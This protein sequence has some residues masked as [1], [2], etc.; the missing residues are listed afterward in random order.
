M[1]IEA[2]EMRDLRRFAGRWRVGPFV[3]GLNVLAAPNEAGKS[4]LLA[5]LQAAIFQ[6]HRSQADEVRALKRADGGP[7]EVSLVLADAA[8]T[9]TITKRFAGPSGRAE[10]IDVDGRRLAGD[11]AEDEVRRL[12]GVAALP[13]KREVPR[14]VWGALWVTQGASFAQ[15]TLD[16]PARATLNDA[17]AAQVGVVTGGA[18]ARRIRARIDETLKGLQTPTGRPSGALKR[19][20]DAASA[21]EERL[22]LLRTRR[23]GVETLLDRVA[24]LRDAI[25]RRTA[26]STAVRLEADLATAEDALRRLEQAA[27]ARAAAERAAEDAERLAD[28]AAAAVQRRQALAETAQA[29]A[30]AAAEAEAAARQATARRDAAIRAADDARARLAAARQAREAAVAALDRAR[31]IAAL[32]PQAATAAEIGRQAADAAE[33]LRAMTDAA[34]KRDAIAVTPPIMKRLEALSERLVAVRAAAESMAPRLS[35]TVS[36]GATVRLDGVTLAPGETARAVLTPLTIEVPGQA[37]IRLTPADRAD[38]DPVAAAEAELAAALAQAGVP[39]LA[40]ARAAAARREA[41]DR[42]AREAEARVSALAGRPTAEAVADLVQR[43]AA[44]AAGLDE[45]LAALGL[46]AVPPADAAAQELAAAERAAETA[47]A[48]EAAAAAGAT[49]AEMAER[50]AREEAIAAETAYAAALREADA[51]KA[52][53]AA[54]REREPDAMLE[55][56]LADRLAIAAARRRDAE[57]V[58]KADETEVTLART[59]VERLRSALKTAREDAA[60]EREALAAAEAELRALEGDALDEAIAREEAAAARARREADQLEARRAALVLL[61]EAI[62]TAER[63]ATERYLAPVSQRLQ[64]WLEALL[65]GARAQLDDR[66]AVTGLTRD[67]RD[68]PFDILSAGTQEQIAVLVRLAFADL[69]RDQGRAAP[70]ILD[71]ALVFSD[72]HRIERMFDILSAASVRMQIVVLTCRTGLFARLG[73]HRLTLERVA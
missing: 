50:A 2:I 36:Q 20:L 31:A 58:P 3:P 22:A 51:A 17:L 32:P 72:D 67:G 47:R 48:D 8:G 39:D 34:A 6:P 59:R 71:D 41:L 37:L 46:A 15:P 16:D 4:S 18:G 25:A 24:S 10:F 12:F 61:R 1:R 56:R 62:D 68:E 54:A 19:A 27:E 7:P 26:A 60:R 5:A 70:V 63:E 33:A 35:L 11:A 9:R 38:A 42:A 73:G 23:A 14:G 29:R 53:L 65:P 52:A 44:L 30:R 49:P 45:R 55:V 57:T 66:F 13:G 28:E 43:A 69:L 40:A 64:P 21:A